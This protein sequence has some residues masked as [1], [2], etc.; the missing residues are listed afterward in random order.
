MIYV[1]ASWR[2]AGW[3]YMIVSNSM[4]NDAVGRTKVKQIY[5]TVEDMNTH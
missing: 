3:K 4:E 1:L 5:Y 2:F